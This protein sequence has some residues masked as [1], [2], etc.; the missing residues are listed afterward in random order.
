MFAR[1]CWMQLSFRKHLVHHDRERFITGS[2][3]FY[4]VLSLLVARILIRSKN[5]YLT[6]SGLI[7]VVVNN[8]EVITFMIIHRHRKTS[9]KVKINSCLF[10]TRYQSLLSFKLIV[11][12]ASSYEYITSKTR[13]NKKNRIVLNLFTISAKT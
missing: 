3:L 7:H 13:K 2:G 12:L 6:S 5:I 10:C 4:C 9:S 8:M 1:G 11:L